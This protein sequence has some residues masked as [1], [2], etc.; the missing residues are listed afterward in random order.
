MFWRQIRPKMPRNVK[1]TCVCFNSKVVDDTDSSNQSHNS[2]VMAKF[3][4]S[5]RRSVSLPVLTNLSSD[6]DEKTG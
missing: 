5:R 4:T 2:L 6:D 3:R 1:I